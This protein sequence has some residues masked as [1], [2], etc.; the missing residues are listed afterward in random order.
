[1]LGLIVVG[2]LLY[3][4]YGWWTQRE[5]RNAGQKLYDMTQGF[6]RKVGCR[7]DSGGRITCK[8]PMD[9]LGKSFT[10]KEAVDSMLDFVGASIQERLQSVVGGGPPPPPKEGG[11]LAEFEGDDGMGR[12]QVTKGMHRAE[13]QPA[14]G[15]NMDDAR[16]PRNGPPP[17][18]AP[19]G[20]PSTPPELRPMDTS[21]RVAKDKNNGVAPVEGIS[22]SGGGGLS[23]GGEFGGFEGGSGDM[24]YNPN[25]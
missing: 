23:T 16:M 11:F 4:A 19:T 5:Q 15:P 18:D 9:G 24:S 21:L 1:M 6:F 12:P 17:M 3:M 10:S 20:R 2:L 22:T 25:L 7:I 14:A 8:E 13:G